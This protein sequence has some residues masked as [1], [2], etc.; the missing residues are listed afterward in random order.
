MSVPTHESRPYHHKANGRFRNPKGSEPQRMGLGVFLKFAREM[1]RQ[2]SRTIEVPEGHALPWEEV[3]AGLSNHE[4]R[5]SL[6]W[7][8]HASFLLRY[9][10]KTVLVDPYLS[11]YASPVPGFGPKRFV[12]SAIPVA[13]LPPIDVILQTHNHYD[14]LDKVTLKAIPNKENIQ[15][16]TAL[17]VGRHFRKW[18][19]SNIEELDWYDAFSWNDLTFT[20]L[21]AVHFSRRGLT[22]TNKDLW[23]GFAIESPRQRI[24]LSGD[25]AYHEAVFH[26]VRERVGPFDLSIVGIGAYEPQAIMKPVHANPEEGLLIAQDIG[27]KT[28]MAMHWGTIVLSIE[29]PFEPPERFRVAAE[30]AGYAEEDVWVLAIG[31]TRGLPLASTD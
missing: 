8:G 9:E 21:P 25:S 12:P 3:Q 30:K 17:G 6:T 19:Y 18:G 15:V 23:V 20:A 29:P 27:S 26:E 5:D 13:Q 10:G 7:L 4:G 14:H 2:R 16:V 28:V 31:E 22:D 24:F 11:E 1:F